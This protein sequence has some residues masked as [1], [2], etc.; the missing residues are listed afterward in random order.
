MMAIGTMDIMKKTSVNF[1]NI[2]E[3]SIET[4]KTFC[5]FYYS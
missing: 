3:S 2:E 4:K 5:A 1:L